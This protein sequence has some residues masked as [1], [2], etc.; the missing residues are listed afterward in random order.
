VVFVT[1]GGYEPGVVTA[2]VDAILRAILADG[3]RSKT[4]RRAAG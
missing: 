4:L 3:R 2:G 1:E